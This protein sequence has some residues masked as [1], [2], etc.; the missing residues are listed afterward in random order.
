M[1]GG[2]GQEGGVRREESPSGWVWRMDARSEG[3]GRKEVKASGIGASKERGAP[4]KGWV[5]ARRHA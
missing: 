5:K 3:G 4:L 2:G 1:R